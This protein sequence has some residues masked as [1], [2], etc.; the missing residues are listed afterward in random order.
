VLIEDLAV[1][2]E[3]GLDPRE[4]LVHLGEAFV[5]PSETLVDTVAGLRH[6]REEKGLALKQIRLILNQSRQSLFQPSLAP[7]SFTCHDEPPSQ[8]LTAHSTRTGT[9]KTAYG[10]C[11]TVPS[12]TAV[13][14]R[15]WGA[16]SA[17][18]TSLDQAT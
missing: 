8:Y 6:L 11:R 16:G 9:G 13:P 4:A 5:N 14:S 15:A 3:N 10:V 18:P 12:R 2:H 7:A 17:A 1:L